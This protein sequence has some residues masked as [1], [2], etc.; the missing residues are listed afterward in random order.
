MS[1]PSSNNPPPPYQQ[2]EYTMPQFMSP[3][4]HSPSL[5]PLLDP[6][7]D[8]P[9]S[10]GELFSQ[11]E[12][13]NLLGFLDSFE[14][15][16]DPFLPMNMPSLPASAGSSSTLAQAT[17]SP[18]QSSSDPLRRRYSGSTPPRP[19]S[20][21]SPPASDHDQSTTPTSPQTRP[22]TKPLLSSPQKRLNH[23]LSEQTR[24]NTIREAYVT[25]TSLVAPA[26]SSA[27]ASGERGRGRTNR[28]RGAR[29]RTRGK[30]KSGVLF[31][32]VE[33]CKWLEESVEGLQKE[34]E[35]LEG[36][37]RASGHWSKA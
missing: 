4:P 5:L 16:F 18:A 23:I 12:H 25:L 7:F 29:G 35:R 22:S 27:S 15:E 19:P 33:Y 6:P 1:S 26:P 14:W 8:P 13:T 17:R 9:G 21:S 11:T 3:L 32:A 30:G 20:P 31:R 10:S 2:F 24:R 37:A 36:I 34:V 28:A